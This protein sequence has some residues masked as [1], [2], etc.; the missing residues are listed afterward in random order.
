MDRLFDF[1]KEFGLTANDVARICGINPSQMRQYERGIRNP[2]PET[3]ERIKSGL[4]AFADRL[5]NVS[6]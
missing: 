6:I 1:V 4:E 3:R 5:K 2:G